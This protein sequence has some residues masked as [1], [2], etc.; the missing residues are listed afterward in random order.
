MAFNSETG[1]YRDFRAIGKETVDQVNEAIHQYLSVAR[2]ASA[3]SPNPHRSEYVGP[4]MLDVVSRAALERFFTLL[5]SGE[6]DAQHGYDENELTKKVIADIVER[7]GATEIFITLSGSA[8]NLDLISSFVAAAKDPATLKFVSCATEHSVKYEGGMLRKAGIIPENMILLPAREQ[9]DGVLDM[10]TLSEA[11]EGIDSEFIFQMAVPT[12]EAVVPPLDE[13]KA[14]VALVH[15]K[16]GKFLLDGARVANALVHWGVG[17]DAL[18]DIG[19][20]GFTLGTSKKGGAAEVVGIFDPEAAKHLHDEAESFGHVSS[21]IAPLALVT[22]VFLN[23]DYWRVEAASENASA[24]VFADAVRTLGI[25]PYFDVSSNM[26]FAKVPQEVLD[27]LAS[28]PEFG[29][30]Y[31]DY[32]REEDISRIVFTGFQSEESMKAMVAALTEAMAAYTAAQA[33]EA[34]TQ[35]PGTDA[36]AIEPDDAEPMMNLPML[37]LSLEA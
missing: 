17:L 37:Q 23:T 14:M 34:E 10:A 22:G 25:E 8:A 4:K 11:L 35:G 19:V 13:L 36:E 9:F 1:S 16:G 7:T 26:V 18:K 12:V 3:G 33:T 21:K 24:Q 6:I 2:E 31:S 20:D 28:H 5:A 27:V 29:G 30:V 15:K 32:G